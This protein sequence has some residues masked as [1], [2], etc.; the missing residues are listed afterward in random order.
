[1]K[2]VLSSLF[3][4]NGI[5]YYH[6]VMRSQVIKSLA[7]PSTACMG[8]DPNTTK[9]EGVI[10]FHLLRT[11]SYRLLKFGRS[12]FRFECKG[13]ERVPDGA[14]LIVGNHSGGKLPIDMLL[15]GAFWH[16][17]FEFQRP[18]YT[19]AHDIL[20]RPSQWLRSNLR[21][22]GVVQACRENADLLLQHGHPVAVLPGGEYET[23]RPFSERN[24][25]DFA[26]RTG[27]IKV[28]LRNEVPISP[29]VCIG[30]H[31]MFFTLSR[32]EKI[33]RLLGL[34]KLLRVG[35][36]PITLGFPW[37][38]YVGPVPSPM[39]LPARITAEVLPPIKLQE[40]EVDHGPYGPEDA[41]DPAKLHEIYSLV[42]T[43]MQ[44]G[45][46]RLAAERRFPVIG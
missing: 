1:M 5:R 8:L 12:Y 30:G 3:K 23:Y 39:P 25:I 26:R 40:A 11:V 24:K 29:V 43:R 17:H 36:F 31:E 46:D 41:D 33:A 45:L 37:G 16:E 4:P 2:H 15:L 32:G 14:S 20:F 34:E 18:I 6:R 28:A 27:W 10:D 44:R 42:T 21:G 22:L 9:P 13:I 19:L 7:Y 38:L 35:S